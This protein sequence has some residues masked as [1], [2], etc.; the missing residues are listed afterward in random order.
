MTSMATAGSRWA[1]VMSRN[2]GFSDQVELLVFTYFHLCF[3]NNPTIT[4][5][6]T[7]CEYG[8]HHV[9]HFCS[10]GISFLMSPWKDSPSCGVFENVNRA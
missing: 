8:V 7:S 3:I 10:C 6:C 1:V 4:G 2:A 5:V 9:V